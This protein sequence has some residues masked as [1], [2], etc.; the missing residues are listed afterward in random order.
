MTRIAMFSLGGTIAMTQ[1]SGSGGVQPALSAS[2]LLAA[3]P[4]LAE[5][6]VTIDI[7]DFR[8]IPGASLTYADLLELASSIAKQFAGGVDGIVVTQG[9]DTIE[10][11]AYILDLVHEGDAPVVVTG[12]MRSAS[13]AG[14]DGPANI[15]AALRTAASATAR[16]LGVLVAFADELHAARY[17]RKTHSTSITAFTSPRGPIGHVV[18][19]EVR[20]PLRPVRRPAIAGADPSRRVRT[21]VVAATV[22][23]DGELLRAAGELSDGLV[24]AAFGAGHVPAGWVSVLENISARKPVVLASRT[25][26]GSVLSSTYGFSGSESDLL[27][28][29]LISAGHL[30]PY[31]AR[32]L[33]HVLMLAGADRV[34]IDPAMRLVGDRA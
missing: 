4:G 29:G 12:A 17:V 34:A 8:R 33:L 15:L 2:D 31:K 11:T 1:Q 21:S 22:D 25:G 20:I 7:H 32:T 10:E 19:N 24:V 28:R 6:G 16:G 30:D 14:A 5:L 9:T 3:V 13:A 27:G 18:E 26:S 23:N